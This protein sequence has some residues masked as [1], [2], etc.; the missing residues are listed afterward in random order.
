[1]PD[2]RWPRRSLLAG[3]GAS[4]AAF[5]LGARPA[6][7]QTRSGFAPARHEQDAWLDALGGTHRVFIDSASTQG[8]SDAILY[9]GNLF[10][11]NQSGYGIEES[12]LAIVVCFR[13]AS[14]A[15]GYDN[16]MWAKYGATLGR[17][18]GETGAG[19]D[20]AATPTANPHMSRGE[21]VSPRAI[22]GLA[23]RGVHYAICDMATRNLSRQIARAVSGD[24]DAI[25]Q[26]L[27]AHPVPNGH[28][29]PAGV[30]AL[31]RAQEYGYSVLIAG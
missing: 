28:F 14:T 10:A 27:V 19:G 21:R 6:A 7:G 11:A 29:V 18:R 17:E 31:T 22:D 4:A 13:H 26:E 3:L 24:A 30:V 23:A 20:T 12:A 16:A 8:G 15:F 5:T 25:Y 2:S 9:A 1:M